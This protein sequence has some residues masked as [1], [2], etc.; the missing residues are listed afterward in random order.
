MKECTKRKAAAIF[1]EKRDTRIFKRV[2]LIHGKTMQFEA[3]PHIIT[4]YQE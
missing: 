3:Y 1:P 4:E 2:N